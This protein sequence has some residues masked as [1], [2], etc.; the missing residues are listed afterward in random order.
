MKTAH[1][2]FGLLAAIL[3]ISAPVTWLTS[4]DEPIFAVMKI[5]AGLASL[6]VWLRG[7]YVH[8]RGLVSGRGG[9]HLLVSAQLLAGVLIVGG[10]AVGFF[11]QSGTAW[12]MTSEQVYT[13]AEETRVLL[14]KLPETLKVEAYY[15]AHQGQGRVLKKLVEQLQASGADVDFELIDPSRDPKRTLAAL[16][17]AESPKI[18][19]RLGEREE[20][21]R[22]P[23]EQ[24]LAQG[25]QRLLGEAR[26]LFVL[27]GHGE[28]E[29]SGE[30]HAGFARL[31]RELTGEGFTLAYLDLARE[32]RIPSSAA[33]LISLRAK[34][35][36]LEQELELIS[37]YMEV[38]GRLLV[39]GQAGVSS[40]LNPLLKSHGL[41]FGPGVVVDPQVSGAPEV[42]GQ[43]AAMV[44]AYTDHAVVARLAASGLRTLLSR[45]APIVMLRG[46][47]SAGG[48]VQPLAA[49]SAESW[50]Q[51]DPLGRVMQRGDERSSGG[52]LL[53]AL[54]SDDRSK[55]EAR[56]SDEARLG[57]LSDAGM[58]SNGGMVHA[59]NR[60]LALNLINWLSGGDQEFA[61]SASE[62]RVSRLFLTRQER[63]RLR[64]L[65]LDALPLLFLLPGLI[66]WQRRRRFS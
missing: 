20:R 30:D 41:S 28:A 7:L 59:G 38:G 60:A 64:L 17:S 14:E 56:R 45:P 5:V 13:V 61:I 63:S 22:L 27:R 51:A 3:L 16:I 57:L 39:A 46:G 53:A 36:F 47:G 29:L 65:L 35:P 9:V 24:Q 48:R 19:L 40:G 2:M 43:P 66:V 33:A 32:G 31:A 62:R 44:A 52:A 10:V 54:W 26:T 23:T 8:R 55:V 49:A 25:L 6:A 18:I 42:Q 11:E 1:S 15:G 58:M 4:L 37:L 21:V 12:D 50:V 34:T